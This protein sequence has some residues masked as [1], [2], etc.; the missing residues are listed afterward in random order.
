[1]DEVKDRKFFFLINS[2]NKGGAERQVLALQKEFGGEIILL[3]NTIEYFVDSNVIIHALNQKVAKAFFQKLFRYFR[4]IWNLYWVLKKQSKSKHVVVV[5]FLEQSNVLNI[6]TSFFSGHFTIVSARINLIA[7]YKRYPWFLFIIKYLYRQANRISANSKGLV[8]QII[9]EFSIPRSKV[10]YVSNAYDIERIEA[11]SNESLSDPSL[12]S[13]IKNHK[14]LLSVNRLEEQKLVNQQIKIFTNLKIHHPQLK[15]IIAGQ[16][17]LKQQLI[18]LAK[19]EGNLVFDSD[20]GQLLTDKYHIYF[21]GLINNPF[22]LYKYTAGFLLTSSFESMP[23]A[24]IEALIC[25]APLFAS[26]CP[27]G[28]REILSFGEA[29][30]NQ[31][32]KDGE[33]LNLIG[34]LL[35]IPL[36]ATNFW[37]SAINEVITKSPTSKLKSKEY[38]EKINSFDV[39]YAIKSWSEVIYQVRK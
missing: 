28:P 13:L 10:F 21:V 20:S 5:S 3:E 34:T 2:L 23:N 1:M 27:F 29:D 32:L 6:I 17:P 33:Q 35:P 12:E 22:R 36:N 11:K 24:L 37:E 31:T 8:F 38:L 16:G 30:Y 19:L 15:L 25:Q 14:F 7:Q 39:V 9:H 18:R 26:D 4:N